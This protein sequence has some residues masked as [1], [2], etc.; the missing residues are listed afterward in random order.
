MRQQDLHDLLINRFELEQD[1]LIPEASL[2]DI[3]MDSMAV[4][5]LVETLNDDYGCSIGEDDI[6]KNTTLGDIAA[7]VGRSQG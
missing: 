6:T 7:L 2:D 3:D 5:E 4:V 1:T